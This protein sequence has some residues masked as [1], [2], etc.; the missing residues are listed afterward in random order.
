MNIKGI[1]LSMLVALSAMQMTST[2]AEARHRGAAIAA[3]AIF[4]GLAIAGAAAA[5]DHE[6][7]YREHHHHRSDCDRH[8]CYYYD[9]YDNEHYRG[10][11]IY[12][13]HDRPWHRHN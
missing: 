13:E 2:P 7:R 11:R 5:H 1:F 12:R 3:G 4:L 9:R 8:G 6:Y 10:D